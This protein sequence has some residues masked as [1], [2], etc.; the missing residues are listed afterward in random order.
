LAVVERVAVTGIVKAPHDDR[1]VRKH[2]RRA[3]TIHEI[4][5]VFMVAMALR[6]WL[7][8]RGR[9]MHGGIFDYAEGR[10]GRRLCG[11]PGI[12]TQLSLILDGS[13]GRPPP[14]GRV[15]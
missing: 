3:E 14:E 1:A 7:L 13:T 10:P 8:W 9:R 4:L 5:I 11:N 15:A 12:G 2:G 6:R